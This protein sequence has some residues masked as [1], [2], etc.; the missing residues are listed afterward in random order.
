MRKVFLLAV[1]AFLSVGSAGVAVACTCFGTASACG[2]YLSADAV[3]VGSVQRIE[4]PP[5][6][7]G[8]DGE[9]YV[10]GQI[11]YIQVEKAFK[12]MKWQT[13][14]IFR[15]EGTSCDP[16][17]KEGQRW[18]FY[19]YYDRKSKQWG[20]QACDRNTLVEH[21]ADDLLY[22]QGLPASAQKTRISGKLTRYEGDPAGDHTRVKSI[23][24]AK[25]K[26]TGEQRT[27]EVYTDKDGVY[28]IYG[29][30][31]GK[32]V[33]EPE[34]LPGLSIRLPLRYGETDSSDES[35]PK[36]VLR[37]KTCAGASFIYSK[38]EPD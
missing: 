5:A 33:V 15:T 21:A 6:E 34:P 20:T 35:A 27:Y 11:A 2:S 24:G 25:V 22:L 4:L 18:L 29:L 37:K 16:E 32:Y 7:K 8:E 9:E 14:V 31:P 10:A 17:Y 19:A 26:I 12:G 38:A 28:E 1:L 36:L 13:Q 3:F 30:P 23:T